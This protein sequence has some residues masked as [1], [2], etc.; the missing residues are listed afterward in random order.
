MF[1]II[2]IP[3]CH[4]TL[5]HQ[6]FL[7]LIKVVRSII[8]T[9]TRLNLLPGT[10]LIQYEFEDLWSLF[11]SQF[12]NAGGEILLDRITDIGEVEILYQL[13]VADV[14][15]PAYQKLELLRPCQPAACLSRGV[16]IQTYKQFIPHRFAMIVSGLSRQTL[17]PP[18]RSRTRLK[19]AAAGSPRSPPRSRPSSP[20][21]HQGGGGGRHLPPPP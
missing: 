13:F 10:P 9:Y 6:I 1:N 21:S 3:L 15:W 18:E 11:R 8:I 12:A 19:T 14:C 4:Y 2:A 20:R 16:S 5:T 7:T 17:T